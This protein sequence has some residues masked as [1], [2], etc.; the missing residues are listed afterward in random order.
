MVWREREEGRGDLQE[1][2]AGIA[3]HHLPG[4]AGRPGPGAGR[5]GGRAARHG[6]GG[7]PA[8]KRDGWSRG[9]AWSGGD[10][11]HQPPRY[12]RSGLAPAWSIR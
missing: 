3:F 2:Q 7:Q 10:R 8:L 5:R 6:E 12:H 1:S 11:S 9:A 4:R